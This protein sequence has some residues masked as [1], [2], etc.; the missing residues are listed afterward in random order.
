M[1]GHRATNVED[2]N[3]L[4]LALLGLMREDGPAEP[5]FRG[6]EEDHLL[7]CV[8]QRPNALAPTGSA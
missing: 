1:G 6:R 3:A 7:P 2:I 8:S 5:G 4:A